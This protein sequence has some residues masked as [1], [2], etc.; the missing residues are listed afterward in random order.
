MS[1]GERCLHV[2]GQQP[3]EVLD[4]FGVGQL[5]EQQREIGVWL[6]VVG[7]RRLDER[8]EVRAGARARDGVGE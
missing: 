2:P 6:D 4:G 1:D 5:G 7:F 3:L 8:I